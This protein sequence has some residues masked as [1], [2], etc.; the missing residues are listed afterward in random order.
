MYRSCFLFP[1]IL[2]G[3][4]AVLIP[5]A[6]VLAQTS[7]AAINQLQ[8]VP[9]TQNQFEQEVCKYYVGNG[10][11]LGLSTDSDVCRV[12]TNL[13]GFYDTTSVKVYRVNSCN[14]VS[15]K[16]FVNLL[17]ASG[18]PNYNL[19]GRRLPDPTTVAQEVTACV[20][21]VPTFA[22]PSWFT[23]VGM[24]TNTVSIA[25]NVS[26]SDTVDIGSGFRPIQFALTRTGDVSQAL[27]IPYSLTGT[28]MNGTDYTWVANGEP[29]PTPATHLYFPAGATQ[30]FYVARVPA[31][32]GNRAE[33]TIRV[34]LAAPTGYNTATGANAGGKI[35]QIIL[36]NV[37][38]ATAGNST[39]EPGTLDNGFT[40]S[41][42]GDTTKPLSLFYSVGGT[43]TNGTDYSYLDG[44]VTIP[45]GQSSVT[46]PISIPVRDGATAIP[47]K[48]IQVAISPSPSSYDATEAQPANFVIPA[49]SPQVV[50]LTLAQGGTT[51]NPGTTTPAFTITR[52]GDTSEALTIPYNLGGTAQNG[53]DYNTLPGSVTIPA[54]Q[55]ALTVPVT[56]LARDGSQAI[57]EKSLDIGIPQGSDYAVDSG[58]AGLSFT[59][60]AY[61]PETL[62]LA[63]TGGTSTINPG[64]TGGFTISRTPGSS[65]TTPI[66]VNYS[67]AGTAT[68]GT[69]YYQLPGVVT[70]PAGADSVNVP[71]SVPAATGSD[72]IPAKDIQ[73]SLAP[74]N[75]YA[76]GTNGSTT[77]TIPAFTPAGVSFQPPTT[78]NLTPGGTQDGFTISR[79]GD[80]TSPLTVKYQVGGSATNG[81]DYGQ[82]PGTITIP[83]GADSVSVPIRAF[84]QSGSQAEPE[85]AVTLTLQPGSGY[86]PTGNAVTYTIP[87]YN[88]TAT[89]TVTVSVPAGGS[90]TLV[91]GSTTDGI[92]FTRTGNVDQPLPVQYAVD[93]TATNGTDYSP[94]DGSVVIPAGQTSVTLP[95]NVNSDATPG[96][97]IGIQ[98]SDGTGY[99]GGT[100]TGVQY[101]IG[102]AP[103]GNA[104]VTLS[105]E[106]QPDPHFVLNR[107]GG[108]V[109]KPLTVP[110]DYS[111]T[112][113]QGVDYTQLPGEVTFPAGQTRVDI[114]VKLLD[115][116][117]PGRTI[118]VNVPDGTGYIVG[119]G[120]GTTFT[121]PSSGVTI[122][123]RYDDGTQSFVVIRD[124]SDVSKSLTT[125]VD[126]SGTA[127]D[128]VDYEALPDNV[129]FAGG[130][131][132]VRIPVRL[133][134][135]AT[136][137]RTITLGIIPSNRYQIDTAGGA[138]F[139]IPAIGDPLPPVAPPPVAVNDK[140]G[141]SGSGSG[142]GAIVGGVAGVG[143]VAGGIAALAGGSGVAAADLGIL[144]GTVFGA[145]PPGC[146]TGQTPPDL[147]KLIPMLKD[148]KVD[149][150]RVNF[151]AIPAPT[152]AG[153]AKFGRASVS[154]KA[155]Q[156]VSEI[157]RLG[158]LDG[159]FNLQCMSL[160]K[161]AQFS[162]VNPAQLAQ[163]K[164][165][166]SKLVKETTLIS[167]SRTVYVRAR[168]ISEIPG[169]ADLLVA[170]LAN[171]STN[172]KLTREAIAK[173]SL[174]DLI[175]QHPE[176]GSIDFG[177]MGLG[178]VPGL[179]NKALLG[180]FP[181]WRNFLISQIPGLDQVPFA[182]FP[183]R[184]QAATATRTEQQQQ[185]TQNPTTPR[186][187]QAQR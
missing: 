77:L 105:Y 119:S 125:P 142:S 130:Q 84:P 132:E 60:P 6:S 64:T 161:I 51:L 31:P 131:T 186:N 145:I 176:L 68:N 87:A 56:V 48:D 129:T 42:S 62:S 30:V 169:M 10:S 116:A 134:D 45:A 100:N 123:L 75:N 165:G 183:S 106:P 78:T 70:I 174:T 118:S 147:V 81:D 108:N 53:V 17:G 178:E 171:S 124:G 185:R 18:D 83:A 133:L 73:V 43:A 76:V 104:T 101:T 90:T 96:K 141:G 94:L 61:A 127:V 144:S 71:V 67:L 52:T 74:G 167:L 14:G 88:P 126:Y 36:P 12:L 59:I 152:Q 25:S 182:Q 38:L 41:R 34:A 82:L 72:P 158:D 175:K 111:G 16:F 122:K 95:L 86:A 155:G 184:P 179:T 120:N 121:V 159:V 9:L 150:N 128:G 80:T 24:G 138:T 180:D 93:G 11:E 89:P 170:R 69:D 110:V 50:S 99:S 143:A 117:T 166:Q 20:S 3:G 35:T 146:T 13:T 2:A 57:P 44:N 136:P 4:S 168:T 27:T 163:L 181:G 149:W 1:L 151:A 49:Y 23:P 162:G 28:A 26:D 47:Q 157:V 63:P 156:K 58:N 65:N 15:K 164:L 187:S 40:I 135:D 21:Q 98:L 115:D 39:L 113:V 79:T 66:T 172:P 137:G 85:E 173:M 33:E 160:A 91:P 109:S 55:T 112:G 22:N 32:Q 103:V 139:I 29:G 107:D 97:T 92:T 7:P 177:T 140:K 46:V 37:S 8:T 102:Q 148:G 154:W 19:L 153:S 54:G 5:T 114:P